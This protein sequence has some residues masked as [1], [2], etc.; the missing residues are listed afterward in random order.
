MKRPL[1]KKEKDFFIKAQKLRMICKEDLPKSIYNQ[2]I[3]HKFQKNA[4]IEEISNSIDLVVEKIESR[5]GLLFTAKI[6]KKKIEHEIR[7]S[8]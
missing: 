8:L 6:L 7:D 4:K 5:R 3:G 1:S 2:M